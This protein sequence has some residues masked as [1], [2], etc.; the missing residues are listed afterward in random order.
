MENS[1]PPGVGHTI[2]PSSWTSH[3]WKRAR[4]VLPQPSPVS[5]EGR[6]TSAEEAGGGQEVR[7]Q[8]CRSENLT[9]RGGVAVALG[10]R[11]H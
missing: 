5:Q 11:S 8:E 1:A 7:R 2:H 6:A 4:C 3:L 9:S 10:I